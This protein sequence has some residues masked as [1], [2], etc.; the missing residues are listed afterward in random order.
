MQNGLMSAVTQEIV[1]M[2]F[3][4]AMLDLKVS[5]AKFHVCFFFSFL[6]CAFLFYACFSS[7]YLL[8]SALEDTE[9][10]LLVFA[11]SGSNPSEKFDFETNTTCILDSYP[12]N[13]GTNQ[14]LEI[15]LKK[16][17]IF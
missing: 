6:E 4:N 12:T 13:Q 16:E 9:K 1:L 15:V 2:V 10:E 14:L 17:T 3:A 11:G 8:F 7:I 5:T